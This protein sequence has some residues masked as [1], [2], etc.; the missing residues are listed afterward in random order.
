MIT[1]TNYFSASLSEVFKSEAKNNKLRLISNFLGPS[2]EF[3]DLKNLLLDF[4]GSMTIR[5]LKYPRP[6]T[7]IPFVMSFLSDL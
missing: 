7:P 3:L 6:P 4:S 2:K 5:F 1:H